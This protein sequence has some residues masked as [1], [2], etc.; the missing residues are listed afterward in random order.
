MKMANQIC[1]Y[2]DKLLMMI[3]I[4]LKD[5][6]QNYL[7]HRTGVTTISITVHWIGSHIEA[8]ILKTAKPIMK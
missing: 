8:I 1:L 3:M 6:N 4:R 2:K 7:L 5:L